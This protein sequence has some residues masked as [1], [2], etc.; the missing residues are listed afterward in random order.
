MGFGLAALTRLAGSKA[1][2][3]TGLR[4]P[5]QNLVTAGTRTGFRAAG[6][7]GRTFKSAQ[8]LGK[9]ARL[10]P[11]ED[12]GLFDLNP[13]EDQRLIV[14]TVTEFAAEQLRP[15][16]ADADTKLLA[17][18]GL[19]SRSAELGITL[20]GIPEEL[21]GVGEGRS[22]VTSALV[23]EALAHGDLGLAVAVL[24]PSAVS[25]SLVLWGDERQQADYLPAF[26]GENVPAA[27]FALLERVPLFD[28]FKP[29]TRAKR[30]P[31]GYQLDGVKSL[32]P[33]AAQAELFV[34]SALL[35][36]PTGTSPALFIVE[37]SN[38][39]V[40]V[41]SEPAMGLR[42]AATG[43]LHLDKVS[44]P[45]GAL[46][47]G[48]KL[49]VFTEAVRLSRLG[50][51]ALAAGTAKAVLD[52]VVPYVNE[53]TAFGEPVSHR[54]AVAFSVADIAIELEGLRLVTLRAA[55]RAEQGKS[56][57]REVALA[58]KLAVDKGMQI[59]NAGVQLLGGHGF[60]KEHPVER[61]YRDLRAI[62]VMEG[63]VLL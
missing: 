52:Y 48:A 7:A 23:A 27:A 13:T 19:L 57:A 61:W 41:E 10:A 11:A 2:E 15:A 44:L 4:G 8:K 53:R 21:G 22:V 51:A 1:V 49:E 29:T 45:A 5:I 38:A 20:I 63:V 3:R 25:T 17:P 56:Y 37:S 58:R 46:L 28:P 12:T 26:V 47:G 36:G 18:E 35:E 24:A 34:V 59:G 16:A 30:T 6:A 14:E 42:G 50:W 40:T 31:K 62:G 9:P 54:Q 60:V 55:A 33:R 32:V 39:G 43:K